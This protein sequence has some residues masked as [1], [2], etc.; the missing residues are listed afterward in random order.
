MRRLGKSAEATAANIF[1][2]GL[3]LHPALSYGAEVQG[4][5]NTQVR[6]FQSIQL[7]SVGM[8]GKGK[9]RTIALALV[10]DRAWEPACAPIIMWATVSLSGRQRHVLRSTGLPQI[11]ERSSS[12]GET[13]EQSCL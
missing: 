6:D 13:P 1:N 4:F 3:R 9:S 7:P 10:D 11:C 5:G 8:F 12:G 2:T